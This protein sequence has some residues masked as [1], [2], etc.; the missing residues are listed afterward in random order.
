MGKRCIAWLL[1]ICIAVI[2][3]LLIVVSAADTGKMKVEANIFK[4]VVSIEV[5]DYAYFGGVTKGYKSND[6]NIAIN[7][8]GTT[9]ISVTPRLANSQE[10]IFNYT[11]FKKTSSD[12]YR[13]VGMFN[14]NISRPTQNGVKVQSVY[15]KLDLTDYDGDIDYDMIKHNAS[16][17]F[18][19]VEK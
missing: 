16:I 19:A 18:W 12:T 9:D 6:V 10:K 15:A 3:F 1:I 14:V 13:L 4:S 2:L 17:I 7:N 5:P 11:Y 8:T